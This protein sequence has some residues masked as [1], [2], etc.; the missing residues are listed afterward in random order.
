M[1]T[2][3]ISGY[4]GNSYFGFGYSSPLTITPTGTVADHSHYQN[5]YES[6]R[7]SLINQGTVIEQHRGGR[8]GLFNNGA[9]IDNSGIMR[10]TQFGIDVFGAAGTVTNSG[11]IETTSGTTAFSVLRVFAGTV[12]NSGL[13]ATADYGIGVDI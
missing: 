1:T 2:S 5:I 8:A 6:G 12:T 7:F 11:T 13:I 3:I 9:Y 4:V 10:G